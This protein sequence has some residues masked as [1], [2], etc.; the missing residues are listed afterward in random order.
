[1]VKTIFSGAW[2]IGRVTALTL[3]ED[4]PMQRLTNNN[5][6]TD[7]TALDLRVEPGE[8]PMTVNSSTRVANLNA[9]LLDGKNST[10]CQRGG[11]LRRPVRRQIVGFRA[12]TRAPGIVP[13]L[14]SGVG[15]QGAP[16]PA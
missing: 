3:G 15:G 6:D 8:A 14:P 7:D 1:M 5:A 13:A 12:G 10:G 16:A 9:D 4:G 2:R 11:A